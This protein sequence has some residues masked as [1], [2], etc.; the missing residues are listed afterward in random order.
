MRNTRDGRQGR[1][2]EFSFKLYVTGASP[3]S[4]RAISNLKNILETHLPGNYALEIIDVHQLPH[5]A[6][7]VDIIALPLLVRESPLPE[8]RMIGDLSNENLII[9]R[10]ELKDL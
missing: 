9:E 2:N 7:A 3:N 5:I 6:K 10:L 8:R 1:V 4:S